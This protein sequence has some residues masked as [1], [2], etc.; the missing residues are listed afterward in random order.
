VTT[1]RFPARPSHNWRTITYGGG[2]PLGGKAPVGD[3]VVSF[4]EVCCPVLSVVGSRDTVVPPSASEPLK[5]LLFNADFE[6]L[7][8]PAGHTGLFIG[9]QAR[10]NCV[11]SIIQW[12]ADHS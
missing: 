8:L 12:L 10:T 3:R 11:P 2:A 4:D 6:T 7:V 5:D 9:R 1:F